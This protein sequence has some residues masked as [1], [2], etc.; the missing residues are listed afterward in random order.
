MWHLPAGQLAH[1]E[2]GW[3]AP[4]CQGSCEDEALDVL[5]GLVDIV[6]GVC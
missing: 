5:G 4:W 2:K 3:P 1:S 6:G